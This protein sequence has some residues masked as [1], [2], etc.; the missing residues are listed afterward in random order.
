MRGNWEMYFSCTPKRVIKWSDKSIALSLPQLVFFL[1]IS[2][3]LVIQSCI[4]K[5]LCWLLPV[6]DNIVSDS[7]GL[8]SAREDWLRLPVGGWGVWMGRLSAQISKLATSS[9]EAI[10]PPRWTVSFLGKVFC[11]LPV[12]DIFLKH[13]QTCGRSKR[14]LWLSSRWT[15]T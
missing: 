1:N 9:L 12:I 5:K 8:F 6:T 15:C 4:W 13:I 10:A 3:Y 14:R 11:Q 2:W 7:R